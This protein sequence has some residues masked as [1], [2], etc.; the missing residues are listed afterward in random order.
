MIIYQPI[1]LL[2]LLAIPLLIVAYV[3][4]QR[5]RLDTIAANSLGSESADVAPLPARR[6]SRSPGASFLPSDAAS[7]HNGDRSGSGLPIA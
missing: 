6:R 3:L 2:G 4:A 7:G 1:F 5:T